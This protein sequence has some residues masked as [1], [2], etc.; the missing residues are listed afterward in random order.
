[1]SNNLIHYKETIENSFSKK[2][3]KY[4]KSKKDFFETIVI[5]EDTQKLRL[6]KLKQLYDNGKI[7]ENEIS[8]KD[9]DILIEMYDNEIQKLKADTNR[10]KENILTEF[11]MIKNK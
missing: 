9:I 5:K 8:D 11:K 4:V 2:E 7:I 10:I 6:K 1:M 3:D